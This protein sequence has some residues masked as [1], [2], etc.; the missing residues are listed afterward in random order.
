MMYQRSPSGTVSSKALRHSGAG[1]QNEHY[2]IASSLMGAQAARAETTPKSGLRNRARHRGDRRRTSGTGRRVAHSSLHVTYTPAPNDA[3]MQHGTTA[4]A[5]PRNN[6]KGID[7]AIATAIAEAPDPIFCPAH[8]CNEHRYFGRKRSLREWRTRH[9][10]LRR[11]PPR[12]SATPSYR[13]F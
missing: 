5:L 7:E 2:R 6:D 8:R 10:A 13:V 9:P 3:D 11:Q 4:L 1:S 12:S